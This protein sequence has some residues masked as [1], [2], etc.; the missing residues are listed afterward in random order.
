VT[1]EPTDPD[2]EGVEAAYADLRSALQHRDAETARREELVSQLEALVERAERLLER[3]RA[4]RADPREEE[5]AGGGDEAP[6]GPHP[7]P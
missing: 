6:R 5:T 1:R 4:L 7:A 2:D 3:A